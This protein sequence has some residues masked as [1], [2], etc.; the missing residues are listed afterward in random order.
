MAVLLR[1]ASAAIA[2][3]WHLPE[4]DGRDEGFLTADL[5]PGAAS[6]ERWLQAAKRTP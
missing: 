6:S 1:R 2:E 5:Q 4:Q 3:H